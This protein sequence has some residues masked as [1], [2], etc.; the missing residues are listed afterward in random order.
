MVFDITKCDMSK[1]HGEC[2]TKCP[3]AEYTEEEAKEEMRLVI[4]GENAK[5]LKECITCGACN[6]YCPLGANPW[7]LIGWRQEQTGI[8]G[9]PIDVKPASDW[10]TK[11]KKV[12]RGRPDGPLI[13]FGGLDEA[14][15]QLEFYSGMMFGGATFISGGDY[16]CEFTETHLGRSSAPIKFLPTF[17]ENLAKAAK[18]FGTNEI[19]FTHDAC[20][21]V[22]TTYAMQYRVKVPFKPI[23]ILNY[24][25]DWL[26]DHKDKIKNKLNIKVAYQGGCTT[27]DAAK[28]AAEE[29]WSDWLNDIFDLIGVESVEEKRKYK[30]VDRLCCGCA[31]FHTEHDRAMEYQRMNVQDALDAGAEKYVFICPACTAVLRTT[32]NKMGLEPIFITQL[33]KLALGEDLG[34]AGTAARGYPVK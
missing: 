17:V 14:V 4:R 29:I 23:H 10:I 30:G 18:E 9:I 24:M 5:I 16:A 12:I 21:N 26:R 11:P 8:L 20:Y 34:K 27:R 22:L 3:Y 13:S 25:R 33:I 7:H 2:L 19:T 6:E 1:C 32:C 31:I 15:P 28:G